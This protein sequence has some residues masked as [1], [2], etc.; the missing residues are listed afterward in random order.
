MRNF[1][2]TLLFILT[3]FKSNSY[4]QQNDVQE[5][6]NGSFEL[7]SKKSISR[8]W[9][10]A[11]ESPD[12]GI[13][14]DSSHVY[15]GK[16][17]LQF[18][19]DGTPEASGA[20]VYNGYGLTS[21]KRIRMIEISAY[22]KLAH[23]SDEAL[24]IF[25]QSLRGKKILTSFAKTEKS[26]L[27]QW[28]LVTLKYT[29]D[30]KESWAGFYYGLTFNKPA[31][32]WADNITV[33]VDGA[34]IS[35]PPSLYQEPDAK[36]ITW[37]NR[38]IYPLA[39]VSIQP[40][41]GDMAAI[42]KLCA[43]AKVVGIGEPTHGTHE[44]L[45]FKL[46][47]LEYLVT[48]KGFNTIA[49][50]EVIPTCDRMNEVLNTRTPSIKEN[51]LAMPFYK[52]WKTSEMNDLFTW[53]YQYN[54]NHPKKVKLIGV[55]MED[56]RMRSSREMIETVLRQYHPASVDQIQKINQKLD[57]LIAKNNPENNPEA[58]KKLADDVKSAI[59]GL[60]SMVSVQN[61]NMGTEQ[62]FQ[63]QTYLR[64]CLQWLDTRFY[65]QAPDT[66]DQYMSDNIQFYSQHHP[67]DKIL[68]WAHNAHISNLTSDHSKTMGAWL[69]DYFKESYVPIAFTSA[70]GSYTAAQDYTQ[71][72]W[73]SFPFE[74]AYR[75]TYSYVL[76]KAKSSLYFLPLNT[77]ALQQKNA[78]WLNV[79]MKQLDITYIQS[80]DGDD[81][82]Y[83]GVLS[84]TFDGIIFCKNTTASISY[85]SAE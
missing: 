11:I 61:H 24:G 78:S 50:E 7:T 4:A 10:S 22:I 44:A 77:P 14:L 59:T 27:N 9:A 45:Q 29:L 54:L 66:R 48:Q 1:L 8:G 32:A 12:Y 26:L 84:K 63:L 64:V 79:A 20:I 58:I 68:V 85:L 16:Y 53:I 83:D 52:V 23:A 57:T 41:H 31:L 35:E 19:A 67:D 75:G 43:D 33:K 73:K 40:K 17:A 37:L 71:K 18:K 42:G 3:V 72:V 56:I 5:T 82:K 55:D 6:V 76:E 38:H 13:Q 51:L 65:N 49:L 70:W 21:S 2:C 30:A 47:L 81:Y 34:V 74:K 36:N 46:R 25:I 39:S 80:G 62:H 60:Q 69:K 15:K 28:Q